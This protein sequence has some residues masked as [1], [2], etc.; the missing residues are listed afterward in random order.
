M[1]FR[2]DRILFHRG[3]THKAAESSLKV[4]KLISEQRQKQLASEDPKKTK[5]VA[6]DR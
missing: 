2:I 5:T 3:Q 4:N 1:I 6:H